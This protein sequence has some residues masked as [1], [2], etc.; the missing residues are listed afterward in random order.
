MNKRTR[1]LAIAIGMAA[2]AAT[3]PLPAAAQQFNNPVSIGRGG[4]ATGSGMTLGY[5]QAIIEEELLNRRPDA[6]V[7]DATGALVE[8]ERRNSG[9][10][11]IR[12]QTAPFV[13]GA[14]A[15][16]AAG[17]M[18]FAV[19]GIGFGGGGGHGAVSGGGPTVIISSQTPIESWI[20]QLYQG[21]ANN[22]S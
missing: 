19:G 13:P 1:L 21:H 11:F 6:L 12:R 16:T 22:A 4:S 10:A 5:R 15:G 9:Q 14:A 18:R 8:V 17:G 20:N 3:I 2:L 7:R